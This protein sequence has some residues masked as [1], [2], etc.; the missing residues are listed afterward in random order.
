[1]R[2][3][4]VDPGDFSPQY[5]LALANA[6]NKKVRRCWL[7]GKHGFDETSRPDFRRDHFYKLAALPF[8]SA[9]PDG[10]GKLTKGLSHG[11]DLYR[12]SGWLDQEDVDVVHFQWL[13]LPLIDNLVLPRIAASRAL[14]VT[15]HD[16]NPYNGSISGVMTRGL[17]ELLR[18]ADKIVVHTEQ[19]QGRL[20]AQG[21]PPGRIVRVPHGLLHE[22][23][24]DT[25]APRQDHGR[26]R[27]L[28]F[29]KIK[30]YKGVDILIEA[31]ARLSVDVRD[32]LDIQI[33]GKPYMDMGAIQASIDQ[34][35]LGN[36]IQLRL[37]YIA[38][39][40]IDALFAEADAALFPYRE[41][42]A[43]GVVMTAI[44]Q[45]LP[46]I[47]SRTGGFGELFDDGLG[48][49][50]FPSEDADALAA[51]LTQWAN[52]PSI[53]RTQRA[54]MH[55][56]RQ[57][58]PGWDQIAGQTIDVYTQVL[59]ARAQRAVPPAANLSMGMQD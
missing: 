39:E 13:P 46:V 48:G 27:L 9:L 51:I 12:L 40:E 59:S 25:Y 49:A 11:F 50:L 26:L 56:K 16:S 31:L 55:A 35:Q 43:S 14:I 20:E 3:A 53:V 6:L 58:V 54:A 57:A 17:N 41:I 52:E 8:I 1:M 32:K 19:A 33:V 30:H 23:A 38:E 34:H 36:C 28:Q 7:V 42:D 44:A 2:V 18:L 47:A 15:M 29:G 24:N 5:N 22:P 45:G 4:I 21:L 37:D 10:A